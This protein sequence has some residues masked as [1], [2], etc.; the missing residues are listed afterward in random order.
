MNPLWVVKRLQGARTNVEQQNRLELPEQLDSIRLKLTE[1]VYVEPRQKYSTMGQM[2][3]SDW[4]YKNKHVAHAMV[5]TKMEIIHKRRGRE[6][7]TRM[8]RTTIQLGPR[9]LTVDIYLIEGNS[10]LVL[11]RE[12]LRNAE[13][14][15]DRKVLSGSDGEKDERLQKD[16]KG[17]YIILREAQIIYE[18][19]EAAEQGKKPQTTLAHL[20]KYFGHPSA[21]SLY[22]LIK[23]SSMQSTLAEIQKIVNDCTVCIKKRTKQPRK[24]VGFHKATAFNQVVSMD[25]KV[26]AN[27]Y[28]L[29]MVDEATRLIRGQVLQNKRPET[30]I[31]AMNKLWINGDGAG[32]GMPEKHFYSDNGREFLNETMLYLL[33]AYNI[34]LRTTAAYTPNQN[35]LNERNHGLAEIVVASL[36]ADDPKLTMQEAVNHAAFVRNSKIN[37]TGYS[38]FQ[39]VYGHNPKIPGVV[40]ENHPLSL[41]TDTRCEIARTMRA[42]QEAARLKYL[43]KETDKKIKIAAAQRTTNRD[44]HTFESGE[45]VWF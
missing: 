26:H 22:R 20:H 4:I 43:E 36:M 12:C 45:R 38:P 29:W 8:L 2:R 11:G 25:L 35:G 3:L 19:N 40:E 15:F 32:P 24:K 41:N 27:C 1:A 44:D 23:Y 9:H 7:V 18:L 5:K 39:L 16:Q 28:I 6:T 13:L 17:T 10:N 21:E 30:I 34:T 42:R 31:A 37:D 33:D 14:R